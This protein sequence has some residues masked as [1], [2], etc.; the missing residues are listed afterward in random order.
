MQPGSIPTLCEPGKKS[1]YEALLPHSQRPCSTPLCEAGLGALHTTFQPAAG[2]TLGSAI[3]GARGRLQGS[4]GRRDLLPSLGLLFLPASFHL[5]NG[6]SFLQQLLTPVS[7]VWW[8]PRSSFIVSLSGMPPTGNAAFPDFWVSAPRVPSLSHKLGVNCS[9]EL[10][11]RLLPWARGSWNSQ[12]LPFVPSPGC[13][14]LLKRLLLLR[15]LNVP[16]FAC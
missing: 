3:G 7:S 14:S 10:D 16:V 2:S 8:T 5:G 15:D 4:G 6:T 9:S 11:T 1:G 13:G 12:Y